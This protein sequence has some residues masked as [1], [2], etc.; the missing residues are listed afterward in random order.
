MEASDPG[1]LWCSHAGRHPESSLVAVLHCLCSGASFGTGVPGLSQDPPPPVLQDPCTVAS[2]SASK[3][4]MS[5]SCHPAA[6]AS[7]QRMLELR[8]CPFTPDSLMAEEPRGAKHSSGDLGAVAAQLP[9]AH[10]SQVLGRGVGWW[11]LF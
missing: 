5:P 9:G 2:P 7:L 3:K 11:T 6:T 4:S 1:L 8:S 10:G